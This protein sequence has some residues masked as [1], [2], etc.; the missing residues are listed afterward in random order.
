MYPDLGTEHPA[1]QLIAGPPLTWS[2]FRTDLASSTACRS[3]HDS[4]ALPQRREHLLVFS[5]SRLLGN[6]RRWVAAMEGADCPSCRVHSRKR[7]DA[8]GGGNG[9]S[10]GILVSPRLASGEDAAALRSYTQASFAL[11]PRGDTSSRKALYEYL[12][13]RSNR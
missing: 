9:S 6:R 4:G 13:R 5:G 11:C 1:K 10:T 7:D 8:R 2:P 12:R 3:A